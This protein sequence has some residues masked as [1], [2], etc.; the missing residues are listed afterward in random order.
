MFVSIIAL[1]VAL[2][3]G[4]KKPE[5]PDY[6]GLVISAVITGASALSLVVLIIAIKLYRQI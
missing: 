5:E 4:W 1:V 6:T 3:Q 2:A